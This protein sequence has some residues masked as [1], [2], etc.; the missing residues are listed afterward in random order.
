MTRT[1]AHYYINKTQKKEISDCSNISIY[2]TFN[3]A[4]KDLILGLNYKMNPSSRRT[5]Y[6]L[7]KP[8][9]L[10]I[11]ACQFYKKIKKSSH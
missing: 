10:Y 1:Y 11:P 2:Y 8:C 9:Q 7:Q 5:L 3:V 4:Q 6:T